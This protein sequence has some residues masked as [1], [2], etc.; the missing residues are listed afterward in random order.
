MEI[1][2]IF[3][4]DHNYKEFRE[5]KIIIPYLEA[6]EN[7]TTTHVTSLCRDGEEGWIMYQ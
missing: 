6:S 3:Q 1:A 5:R 2:Q 4:P 7:V